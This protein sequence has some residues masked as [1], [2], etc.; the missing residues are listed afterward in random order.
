MSVLEDILE[1]EYERSL[2]LSNAMQVEYDS[3]PKGSI[4][5]RKIKGREYY[6]LNYRDKDKVLSD[7]VPAAEVAN[8]QA[9]INRRRELKEALK[10]QELSRKQIV[11]ALGKKPTHG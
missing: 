2:R 5:A 1:E 8:L 11:R 7:Y 6:Y 3:L 10:E 9:K 4:R